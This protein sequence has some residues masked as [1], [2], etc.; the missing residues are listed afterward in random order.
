MAA[1]WKASLFKRI[2]TG[3]PWCNTYF[4]S[5]TLIADATVVAAHILQFEQ[6][7]HFPEI[8]FFKTR[9]TSVDELNDQ[10]FNDNYSFP[11]L[12][13][14]SA[15]QLPLWNTLKMFLNVFGGRPSFK[16]YRCL[17]E[18]DQTSGEI[19]AGLITTAAS[20]FDTFLNAD[21]A[22]GKL[23]DESGNLF[24]SRSFDNVVAPRSRNRRPK[25]KLVA[26][27]PNPT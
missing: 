3:K 7:I 8:T 1:V 6:A 13:S 15:D 19:V 21:M 22:A 10:F 27:N 14:A 24:T 18:G 17:T 5:D 4:L 26:G 16:Y 9:I 25:R 20:A 2:G 11:G 12:R 23:V